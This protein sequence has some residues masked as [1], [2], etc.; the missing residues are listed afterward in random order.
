MSGFLGSGTT[1]PDSPPPT[2]V[3]SGGTAKAAATSSAAYRL[4]RNRYCGVVLLRTIHVVGETVV[5]ANCIELGG[6]LIH[7]G[8]PTLASVK[9]DGG[10][11]IIAVHHAL[12]IFGVDP[13]VMIIAVGSLDF[14]PCFA[15]ITGLVKIFGD[16]CVYGIALFG[17][18]EDVAIVILT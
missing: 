12:V 18:G 4:A 8:G 14:G 17:I 13:E 11:A 6:R 15:G 9:G 2:S 10:P 5:G 3:K 1:Y 16:E 7:L